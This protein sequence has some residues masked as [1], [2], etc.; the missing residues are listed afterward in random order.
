MKI[1]RNTTPDTDAISAIPMSGNIVPSSWMQLIRM[2]NG[3]QGTKPDIYA[4]HLLSDIIYWYRNAEVRDEETGRLMAIKKRFKADYMQRSHKQIAEYFGISIDT[5]KEIISRLKSMGLIET[6]IQKKM[7]RPNLPPLYNVMYIRPMPEAIARLQIN[8]DGFSTVKYEVDEID[9]SGRI[10]TNPEWQGFPY[11]YRDYGCTENTK[12]KE[13]DFETFHPSLDGCSQTSNKFDVVYTNADESTE[14]AKKQTPSESYL[15]SKPV[16]QK[17][18]KPKATTKP[19]KALF[20]SQIDNRSHPFTLAAL[21]ALECEIEAN[22]GHNI[23]VD[24]KTHRP[25]VQI[26]VLD[27]IEENLQALGEAME[28]VNDGDSPVEAACIAVIDF[29]KDRGM[30]RK[31]PVDLSFLAGVGMVDSPEDFVKWFSQAIY[32]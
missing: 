18:E 22:S 31:R 5:S 21:R 3:K 29:Y 26:A 28:D 20:A 11:I 9:L 19:K 1:T 32:C 17:P 7:E 16:K 2:P 14:T 24:S 25:M 23:W 13:E 15:A 8:G 4:I 27:D 30:N 6:I 10:A 12:E